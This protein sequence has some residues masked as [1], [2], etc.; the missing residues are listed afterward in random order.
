MKNS[1]K[2]VKQRVMGLTMENGQKQWL[3]MG[4]KIHILLLKWLTITALVPIVSGTILWYETRK[5]FMNFIGY[6][7][8]VKLN[9]L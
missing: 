2:V 3:D 4:P 8:K 7:L 9:R 1:K 5:T 6:R